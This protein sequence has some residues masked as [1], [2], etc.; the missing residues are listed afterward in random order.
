MVEARTHYHMGNNLQT[1]VLPFACIYSKGN[2]R[3]NGAMQNI[4]ETRRENL[5]HVIKARF[6]GSITKFAEAVDYSPSMVS[7]LLSVKATTQQNI[8]ARMARSIEHKIKLDPNW[9]DVPHDDDNTLRQ[10]SPDYAVIDLSIMA[11][12]ISLVEDYLDA[13]EE[14]LSPED[15]A[16]VI[17]Y[18]YDHHLA[19]GKAD[20]RVI[21]RVL[22]LRSAA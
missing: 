20:D 22:R 10:D 11:K 12:S 8:G 9:L 7:R 1:P 16:T 6:K 18:V 13:R 3:S 15:K 19:E 21:R 4:Y 14:T 17:A 5:R 2:A